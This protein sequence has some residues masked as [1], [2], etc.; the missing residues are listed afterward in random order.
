M[1][2]CFSYH[3][4][5]TESNVFQELLTKGLEYEDKIIGSCEISKEEFSVKH[6]KIPCLAR[7]IQW[8]ILHRMGFSFPVIGKLYHRDHSTII[9]G[10][11]RIQGFI[12]IDDE[13]A[14]NILKRIEYDYGKAN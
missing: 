12:D 14:I 13:L 1:K 7:Q 9:N 11:N 5:L 3:L 6:T 10:V 2:T 8:Y 4:L